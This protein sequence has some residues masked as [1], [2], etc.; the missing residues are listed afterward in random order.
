MN[1]GDVVE[2]LERCLAADPTAMTLGQLATVIDEALMCQSA[3]DHLMVRLVAAADAIEH[4]P[5]GES[6]LRRA[7]LTNHHAA[8]IARRADVAAAFPSFAAALAD[9]AVRG[10]HLDVLG[11]VLHDVDEAVRSEICD[12]FVADAL[13][14]VA[15]RG[16]PTELARE[17]RNATRIL[18]Q[19]AG[20]TEAARI[21]RQRKLKFTRHHD[22]TVSLHGNLGVDG[23]EV[24][25][26]IEQ[27]QARLRA[28]E[29][30]L[31]PQERSTDEQLAAD[32]L[33]SLVR[34][35]AT[36]GGVTAPVNPT[37]VVQLRLDDLL[38]LFRSQWTHA[39]TSDGL[40]LTAE[41]VR[42][43]VPTAEIVPV[44]FDQSGLPVE[45]ARDARKR[46]ATMIQR[47]VLAAMYDSCSVPGCDVP[48]DDCDVHHV[49]DFDGSNTVLA[50][51]APVC[52]QDH[53][54]HH[55]GRRVITVDIDRTV[56]I[57]LADGT[58]W[59][60]EEYRPPGRRAP[61]AA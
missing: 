5:G 49:G 45:L 21:R 59:A 27:E 12:P 37:F 4:G 30:T 48:F 46:L 53:R 13:L 25:R 39:T 55:A 6:L 24:R 26:M 18:D 42:N 33:T 35:G 7:R 8:K 2:R 19:R 34:G 32:A 3:L 23:A 1:V 43:L 41:F 9:G 61:A 58:V 11:G 60:R 31:D 52:R 38:D 36:H 20:E 56:R 15:Q 40:P 17:A 14:G 47:A 54:E 10:E 29:R 16:T 57:T 44:L 22:G 51:L 28:A 50:N